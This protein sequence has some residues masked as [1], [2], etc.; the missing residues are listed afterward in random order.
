[1][2]LDCELRDL[3]AVRNI[4]NVTG[5]SSCTVVQ[6]YQRGNYGEA[7][8]PYYQRRNSKKA[9]IWHWKTFNNCNGDSLDIEW[10]SLITLPSIAFLCQQCYIAESTMKLQLL[11]YPRLQNSLHH[12]MM[13]MIEDGVFLS[14]IVQWWYSP[15]FGS[16]NRD[17]MRWSHQ[18]DEP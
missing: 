7:K 18:Q 15:P 2:I 1:M 13:M 11:S 9:N 4:T 5:A 14:K 10:T 3:A 16:P 6:L 12:V 8:E 17:Y